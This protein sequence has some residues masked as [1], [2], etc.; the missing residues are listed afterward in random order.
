MNDTQTFFKQ[1][2]FEAPNPFYAY[3]EENKSHYR[4]EEVN[5]MLDRYEITTISPNSMVRV[6][7]G[8]M[9][10]QEVSKLLTGCVGSSEE[11]FV[12]ALNLVYR[13]IYKQ[14]GK[15]LAA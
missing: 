8:N 7:I 5:R 3:D 15:E 10:N 2:P 1:M 13:T 14:L 4:I 11:T 6:S 9:S 12:N